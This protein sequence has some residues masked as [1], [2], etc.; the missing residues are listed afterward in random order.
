MNNGN[1]QKPMW[2]KRVKID[3]EKRV[4][5]ESSSVP[6]AERKKID[7]ERQ[8]WNPISGVQPPSV[9]RQF[10]GVNQISPFS[11]KDSF[12]TRNKNVSTDKYPSLAVRG[13]Y[14]V[15]YDTGTSEIDGLA[16]YQGKEL[17]VIAGGSWRRYKDGTWTTIKTGLASGEKWSFVN[18]QGGFSTMHLL[19]TNG[20]DAALKYDGTSVVNLVNAPAG[21]DFISSHNNRVYI[22]AKSTVYFSALRK[23]EDWS[24]VG[25]AGQLVVE[26][27][28]GK[29]ITGIIS[30]SAR[31]TIF[32]HNSVHELFGT[33]PGN[34]TMKTVTENV[35][36][37]T[38]YSAQVIDGVIYFLGNDGVYQYSG[39]SMPD[40]EFS[41]QVMDTI[42]RVNPLYAHKSVSWT[43]GIRY[44]LAVPTGGN[45][46]PDTVL[47]YDPMFNIWNTW[48]FNP[49]IS[50]NAVLMN[51]VL[52]GGNQSGEVMKFD[53][54]SDGGAAISWEWVSKPFSFSSLAAKSRWFR[55]W[56]V[57][58]VP[59]GSTMN[60]HL[61]D[62]EDGENWTLVKTVGAD[63]DVQAQEILIPITLVNHSNFI[64]VRL[65]GSGPVTVYEVSR[66]ERVFPMG[67]N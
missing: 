11:I 66:Q 60:I 25:E 52:Y 41:L 35:G 1:D 40:K 7:V 12:A 30:G 53:A 6:F 47:Q 2:V 58:D 64:R 5:E 21:S 8:S 42:R 14:S 3:I 27:T 32:K 54:S 67:I 48:E 19:A 22:A 10:D 15:L 43:D 50:A 23:A 33:N 17:H 45:T 37:P 9:I 20:I 38:G 56:A 44:Y 55:L 51:G 16:V 28:D 18:F 57:A 29:D 46:S 62:Q 24:T 63:A 26:T 39:G 65:S 4:W 59:S 61:S 49:R 34:Y 31:L 36:S 13:G